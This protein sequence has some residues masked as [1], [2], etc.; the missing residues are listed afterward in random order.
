[1]GGSGERRV[2]AASGPRAF[3]VFVTADQN[4]EFQQNLAGSSLLVM[5]LVA[6]RNALEDLLP[7]VPGLLAAIPR[8]RP[9]QVMRVGV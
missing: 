4:P 2:A 5:V 3:E 8:G 7:L 6:R 1:L 9:G